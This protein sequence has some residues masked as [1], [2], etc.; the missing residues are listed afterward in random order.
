[1]TADPPSEVREA[2]YPVTDLRAYLA[3]A[4]EIRRTLDDRRNGQRG[5][6]E[7]RATFMPLERFRFAGS[8]HRPAPPPGH[9]DDTSV[10]ARSARVRST[11]A[12]PAHRVGERAGVASEQLGALT[13]REE[14]RLSLGGFETLAHQSYLYAFPATHRAHRAEVRFADGRAF[15]ALDLRDGQWSAEH[16]CAADLYRGRFRALAPDRWSVLWTVTGPRKDQV[17]ESRFTRAA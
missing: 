17:L 13:Y 6:F 9:P 1:M 12:A 14:G 4:W 7:G 2:L 5:S 16:V 3:G 8:L 10:G 15:H 11:R